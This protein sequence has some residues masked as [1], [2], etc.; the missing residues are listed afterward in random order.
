MHSTDKVGR[1]KSLQPLIASGRIRF[2]KKHRL[3]L[4]QLRQFPKAAHDDGPDALEMAVAASRV[5]RPG[6]FFIDLW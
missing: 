4:E 6:I 2:S 1:I 5:A 3:L